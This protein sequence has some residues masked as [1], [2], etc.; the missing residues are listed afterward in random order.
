MASFSGTVL[1]LCHVT[2][3]WLTLSSGD[4]CQ[5]LTTLQTRRHVHWMYQVRNTGLITS[6]NTIYFLH[7]TNDVIT[8]QP[9][10]GS[11]VENKPKSYNWT[12]TEMSL[13]HDKTNT[14]LV[15]I[16][17]RSAEPKYKCVKFLERSSLVIQM[18]VSDD[19][20]RRDISKCHDSNLMLDIWPLI[21]YTP[22]Q[23]DYHN[24]NCPIH[25][26]FDMQI[27]D[28]DGK[29]QCNHQFTT[30]RFESVCHGTSTLYLDF[31]NCQHERFVSNMNRKQL[32]VCIAT[33]F[34]GTNQFTILKRKDMAAFWCLRHVRNPHDTFDA[35]LLSDVVCDNSQ[36]ISETANV[37]H[38]RLN[39]KIYHDICADASEDCGKHN[40]EDLCNENNMYGQI[41][42]KLTCRLCPNTEA[43]IPSGKN[44]FGTWVSLETNKEVLR[45]DEQGIDVKELGPIRI[46]KEEDFFPYKRYAL[47]SY[48]K[49]GCY[50]RFNCLSLE[51]HLPAMNYKLE[52]GAIWP[53]Y[54]GEYFCNA[55]MTPSVTDLEEPYWMVALLKG[56][57]V[58]SI[59]CEMPG[60]V[61]RVNVDLQDKGTCTG[62]IQTNTCEGPKSNGLVITFSSCSEAIHQ[63]RRS[64]SCVT[65]YYQDSWYEDSQWHITLVKEQAYNKYY[66]LVFN[67]D[68]T[69]SVLLPPSQ[70]NDEFYDSSGLET[71][72]MSSQNVTCKP[73][74]TNVAYASSS[75]L[76]THSQML[77]ALC[78][79]TF[80]LCTRLLYLST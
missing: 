58:P 16:G 60:D 22:N 61:Y 30:P 77:M 21:M 59:P 32:L 25:G 23:R 2:L 38:L 7:V 67:Q 45:I 15:N 64:F 28:D 70:C 39:K 73:E 50:P 40:I 8:F 5:F 11:N 51:P 49:E 66:C 48:D 4:T 29:A 19:F 63:K 17:R 46:V 56:D 75:V 69:R 71:Y 80:Y 33:W 13:N 79:Q 37:A 65:S 18:K 54:E 9:H 52:S 72:T 34:E 62:Q 6:S 27:M 43:H 41:Y 44:T 53:Q 74:V 68:T 57:N 35:F 12:C 76:D 26:G 42:C 24:L 1:V 78:F 3:S 14:F 47:V 10:S 36:P 31:K 20:S 55:R